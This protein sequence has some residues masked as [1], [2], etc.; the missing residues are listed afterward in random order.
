MSLLN[1]LIQFRLSPVGF[2]LLV[3]FR[4]F[5]VV[6]RLVFLRVSDF[7]CHPVKFFS[8]CSVVFR[9]FVSFFYAV[10]FFVLDSFPFVLFP[11]YGVLEDGTC[12]RF[13]WMF[14]IFRVL[15]IL[16][17]GSRVIVFHLT[18]HLLQFVQCGEC[19]LLFERC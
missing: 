16:S 13:P 19:P 12:S 17:N 10:F 9:F 7:F 11:L 15:L 8:S 3:Y 2:L 1:L 6:L 18:G 14:Y 4:L 5:L